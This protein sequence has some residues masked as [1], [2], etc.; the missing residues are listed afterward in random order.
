MAVV[1]HTGGVETLR[2]LD[3]D[4]VVVEAAGPWVVVR[5]SGDASHD[6]LERYLDGHADAVFDALHRRRGLG[7]A[8]VFR[9]WQVDAPGKAEALVHDVLD[10]PPLTPFGETLDLFGAFNARAS[11]LGVAPDGVVQRE[12]S[13]TVPRAK[14]GRMQPPHTEFG[15][16]PHRPR[17][18]AFYCEVAP[19]DPSLGSTALCDLAG[20]LGALRPDDRERLER[21]GWWNPRARVPQPGALVHPDSGERVLGQLYCLTNALSRQALEAYRAV[22]EAGWP[23]VHSM[24]D[25]GN[26]QGMDYGFQLLVDGRPVD[27]E[28]VVARRLLETAFRHTRFFRWQQRDLLLFDNLL[29]A[30]WRMPGAPDR[31]LHAFFGAEADVRRFCPDD[32]PASVRA[33]MAEPCA[34]GNALVLGTL[35]MGGRPWALRTLMA[36]P[37]GWFTFIGRRTWARAAAAP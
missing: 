9:G 20:T 3:D 1:A 29:F 16:G 4:A 27:L 21:H 12:R 10:V 17:V 25:A 15:L 7:G 28:G 31:R 24:D 13:R 30:H 2:D 36:L 23:E 8:V 19:S 34:G 26:D 33:A 35:G 32:A 22:R 6:A 37:D 5:P 14:D 18:G 11:R